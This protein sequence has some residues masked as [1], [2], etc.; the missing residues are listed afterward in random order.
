MPLLSTIDLTYC[1]KNASQA[2]YAVKDVSINVESGTYCA[3]VGKSGSGK[4]TLIS[5]LAGLDKPFSGDVLYNGNSLSRINMR[6]YR[7]GVVSVIYQNYN[8]FPLLTMLENIIIPLE[9]QKKSKKEAQKIAKEALLKVGL[10]STYHK[11][12]PHMLSGGEQQRV[13][14]ARSLA[15]GTK[16][17]L[18]DEP[19]GNC[20]TSNSAEIIKLLADLA[21]NENRCVIVATH[22]PDVMKSTDI[23]YEMRDGRLNKH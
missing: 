9:I 3:I 20:D 16:I 1:Y 5:L 22:D 13:A 12:Y 18:A 19:T 17:L 6:E 7:L 11:R 8:L 21:Y 14:I 2:V 15:A 23:V 10:D 4:S